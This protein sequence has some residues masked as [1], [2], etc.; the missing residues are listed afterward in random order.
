MRA[1]GRGEA[2][3]D[4]LWL[5]AL[6]ALLV[7]VSLD[8]PLLPIDETR[9]AAVAWE[10]WWRGDFL[11]PHLNGEPYHHKPP[12]LFW[13][14]HASWAAFGVSEWAMRLISPLF[15]AGTLCLARL[16]ARQLWPARPDVARMAPFIVLT[17][18][19]YT[20]FASAL[21]FDAMLSFFVALGLYGLVLAWRTDGGAPGF[22]WLALGMAG[23]LFSKGP[24]ALLHLLPLALFAPWWMREQR[25]NWRR[26][27]LG[28]LAALAAAAALILAWAIPAG[29]SGGDAYRNAIFWG[30]TAN[31]MV[32]SFAHQAPWWFYLAWLPLMLAPWLLWPHWWRGLHRGLL[33][34]SGWRFALAGTLFC[35]LAFSLVSGKRPHYLLPEFVLFAL[36]TAR[37]LCDAPWRRWSLAL[38]AAVLALLGAAAIAAAP[39]LAALA[40]GA[41]IVQ[42]L[43]ALG[44][45]C[46][47]CALALAL[48]R[49][50]AVHRDVRR[51]ATAMLVV[52]C[53][54]MLVF[55]IALREPY[56]MGSVAAK[57]A[58]YE[59]DGRPLAY[60]GDYHGQWSF[61]GRLRHAVAEVPEPQ[62]AAWLVAHPEGRALFVYKDEAELPPSTRIEYSRPYRGGR[63]AILAAR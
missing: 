58:Q 40:A 39:R 18:L 56:D 22:V 53:A 29:L 37:A 34:E 12:L 50:G 57:L 36:L 44:A 11:V 6:W 5:A 13:L 3:A 33:G 27:S 17:S 15:A 47:L 30:Q 14:I 62:I 55:D 63:V 20:Y 23:A 25:P 19:L 2:R 8:R 16:L 4:A 26:W 49:P 52:S 43:W 38:P 24:V 60:A 1:Q 9:Y 45:L 42:P 61:A 59:S 35:L 54:L 51:L 48:P 10:M 7:A 46:L 41:D 21:M 32:R 31:R 28:V